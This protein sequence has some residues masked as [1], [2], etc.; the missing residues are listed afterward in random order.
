M[1]GL[2]ERPARKTFPEAIAS[3]IGI[4]RSRIGST[5]PHYRLETLVGSTYQK[6]LGRNGLETSG[7][8]PVDVDRRNGGSR[9]VYH[10]PPKSSPLRDQNQDTTWRTGIPLIAL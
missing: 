9:R 6:R 8:K 5:H 1:K 3:D 7:N 4:A 2:H 10:K